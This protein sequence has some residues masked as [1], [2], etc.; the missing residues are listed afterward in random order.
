MKRQNS[1][2]SGVSHP[3]R[4]RQNT[5]FENPRHAARSTSHSERI[6]AAVSR[7]FF[8]NEPAFFDCRS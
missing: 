5:E 8:K 3:S 2:H 7:R 4:E 6:V 1:G